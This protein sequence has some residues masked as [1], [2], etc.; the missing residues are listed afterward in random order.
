MKLVL[1]LPLLLANPFRSSRLQAEEINNATANSHFEGVTID[2]IVIDNQNI[3]DTT[4]TSYGNFIFKLANRLHVKTKKWVIRDELLLKKGEPY[5]E[6]LAEES[7]RNMRERLALYDAWIET[8]SL[9]DGKLLVR[10]VTIDQWSLAGGAEYLREGHET[11]YNFGIE[12]RNLLGTGQYI[13]LN[14]YD[15]SLEGNYVD[16]RYLNQRVMGH[17]MRVSFDYS[18]DPLDKFRAVHIGHPYYDLSQQ[19]AYDFG[20]VSAGGRRDV[21]RDNDRIAMSERNG[22]FTSARGAY[23]FGDSHHKLEFD[24]D[25]LYRFEKNSNKTIVS[26]EPQDSLLARASFPQDSVY[27]Q[28]Q[29]TVNFSTFRYVRFR[30]VDGIGYTEDFSTGH[31][32]TGSYGRAFKSDFKGAVFDVAGYSYAHNLASSKGILL[33][34]YGSTY[35]YRGGHQLRHQ[36]RIE[37]K[38]YYRVFPLATLAARVLYDSDRND[39]LG[40]TLILGGTTGVRGFPK[41][42]RSGDRRLVLNLEAR[43]HSNLEILSLVPG[44]VIFADVGNIW[45]PGAK[46]SV[47]RISKSVGLGLRFGFVN[48]SRNIVRI[49]LSYSDEKTWDLTIG[50]KQY[51]DAHI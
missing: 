18:N 10:V 4:R 21:Y 23:R 20:L 34:D 50:T 29:L 31:F 24:L 37:T 32:L 46:I 11:T 16:A 25:Y 38:Y 13:S 17:P 26:S 30:F 33:F 3:F 2:S 49:D 41:F 28:G 5:T 42:Y 1:V 47:N 44:G 15:K 35:W 8:E 48:S 39:Q 12:E 9:P 27:H 14:Y 51:F 7:A 36:L 40:Q 43:V 6:E 19:S 45:A 22:N